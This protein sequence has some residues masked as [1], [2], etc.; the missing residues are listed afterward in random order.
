MSP[1][2]LEI[3]GVSKYFGGLAAI[4][5]IDIEI[6]EGG[7]VGL[8]GPNGA[9]KTTLFNL[10][11]GVFRPDKGEIF[12]NGNNIA[13]TSRHKIPSF[14]IGRTFQIPKPFKNLTVYE[15]VYLSVFYSR[16]QKGKDSRSLRPRVEALLQKTGLLNNAQLKAAQLT[17]AQTKMLEIAR[18]LG[19]SPKLLLLDEQFSGLT[20]SE[21]EGATELIRKLR[22]DEG[23][24]IFWI[25]HVMKAI[26][27]MSNRVI[28][29][30]YG[31][32]IADGTPL[33]VKNDKKVIEAYFGRE[34][35]TDD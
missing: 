15:N 33:E 31:E 19:T 4:S 11:S 28:V 25:E 35:R 3:R 22:D 6:G 14:G 2:K 24:T 10:I 13:T 7:I 18:S 26:M 1:A 20:S 9:G 34:A 16:F 5:N 30:N 8:L 29:L 32:K 21:I 12:F 17:L 23:I 27:T